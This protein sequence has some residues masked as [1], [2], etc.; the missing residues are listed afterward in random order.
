MRMVPAL[1]LA[2]NHIKAG[3]VTIDWPCE[4]LSQEGPPRGV[5]VFDDVACTSCGDCIQ[6]CPS[7]SIEIPEG[8][9][10]PIVDA[11]TCVGCGLCVSECAEGA[12]S[13]SGGSMFAAMTRSD[14]VMDGSF[15]EEQEVGP[16]P[17][18]L[19]RW[20]VGSDGVD[21]VDPA[22]ILAERADRLA[23]KKKG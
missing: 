11:G 15:P 4:D 14:L 7:V 6:V 19:Y 22:S 16:S 12:V 8:S 5:P 2:R 21:P 13:L 9:D 23:V 18:R 1:W 20:A 3:V 17:G 10:S